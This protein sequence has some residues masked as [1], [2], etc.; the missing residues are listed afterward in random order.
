MILSRLLLTP[1]IALLLLASPG[2]M[3]FD[4]SGEAQAAN[5]GALGGTWRGG[6]KL[7]LEGKDYEVQDGELILFRF[8]V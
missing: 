7:R 3:S 1:F 2:D 6:G 4:R 8:N 5:L